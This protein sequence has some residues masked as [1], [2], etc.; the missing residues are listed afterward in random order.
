MREEQQ[1]DKQPTGYDRLCLGLTRDQRAA[2]P[3]F[4]Q[5]PVV[6]ML[7][8]EDVDSTFEDLILGR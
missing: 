3:G 4:C 2:M 6:R 8:P 5:T 7:V 1:R